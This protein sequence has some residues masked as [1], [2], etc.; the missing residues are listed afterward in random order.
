MMR[1]S[2]SRIKKFRDSYHHCEE[3]KNNNKVGANIRYRQASQNKK[4]LKNSILECP[5]IDL[6]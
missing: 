5:V 6:D 1:N 4:I 2:F 3:I